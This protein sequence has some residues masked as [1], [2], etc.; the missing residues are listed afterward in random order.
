MLKKEKNKTKFEKKVF[1]VQ[2]HSF[3]EVN[4]SNFMSGLEGSFAIL[5]PGANSWKLSDRE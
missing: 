5:F 2:V 4:S 3:N 1:H